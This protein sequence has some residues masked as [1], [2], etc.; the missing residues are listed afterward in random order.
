MISFSNMKVKD[1]YHSLPEFDTEIISTK[2]LKLSGDIFW[3]KDVYIDRFGLKLAKRKK[4][5]G[6]TCFGVVEGV[7]THGKQY[8]D[9][10]FNLNAIKS[11][12]NEL[13]ENELV[14]S[15]STNKTIFTVDYNKVDERFDLKVVNSAISIMHIINYDFLSVKTR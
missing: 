5:N 13:N 15:A 7:D 8:N 1:S 10:I 3:G 2:E 12:I 11:K 14:D 9:F 6:V 4:R